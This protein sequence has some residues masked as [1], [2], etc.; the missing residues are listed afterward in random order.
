MKTPFSSQKKTANAQTNDEANKIWPTSLWVCGD[1]WEECKHTWTLCSRLCFK[2]KY[3]FLKWSRDRYFVPWQVFFFSFFSFLFF[4]NDPVT[5]VWFLNVPLTIILFLNDPVTSVLF[6]KATLILWWWWWLLLY[7]AI[8]RSRADSLRSHVI[9][10]EWLAFY[11]AFFNIHRSGVLTALAWL[12][13]L[14]TA[15]WSFYTHFHL[16]FTS[17]DYRDRVQH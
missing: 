2:I 4:L 8:P 6:L 10:R 13:P 3:F 9:L 12:V 17:N 15:V 14:V 1:I 7:S 5:S 11:S 16:S